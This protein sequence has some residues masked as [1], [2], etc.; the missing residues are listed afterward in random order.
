MQESSIVAG[1]SK[2]LGKF[3]PR[4]PLNLHF[5]QSGETTRFHL[6]SE[7]GIP[8]VGA[9][10]SSFETRNR[11]AILLDLDAGQKSLDSELAHALGEQG[12]SVASVDLRAT[13]SSAH[14]RDTIGA[15]PDHNTTEWSLWIGRPLLGQWVWDT[16]RV[17]EGLQRLRHGNFEEVALVG[18]GPAGV[19]ALAAAVLSTGFHKV[20]TWGSLGTLVS[21]V[22]YVGQRMG[23]LAPGL[24][25]DAGDIAHLA[26]TIS[27]RPLIIANSLLG[28]GDAMPSQQVE[29]TFRF[30]R[31]AY[32]W[33]E[34][35]QQLQV[36]QEMPVAELA[37]ALSIP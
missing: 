3:P 10:K 29:E 16:V 6:D 31:Q 33:E 25:R 12:W 32:R 19:V 5:E 26:A 14:P 4:T 37:K 24:L 1:L 17:L 15:A 11:V 35:E 20:A 9:W 8:L 30:T 13:A 23:I 28:S 18:L 22:P 7:P 2:V 34:A 36:L 21:D 27:P